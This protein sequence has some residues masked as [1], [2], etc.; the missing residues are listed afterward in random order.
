[1]TA[2]VSLIDKIEDKNRFEEAG[3]KE[4]LLSSGPQTIEIEEY[5][6]TFNALNPHL[7][8][9][10][11]S[12]TQLLP[13]KIQV[14]DS[15]FSLRVLRLFLSTIFENVTKFGMPEAGRIN[16]RVTSSLS[17]CVFEN[18]TND[19]TVEFDEKGLRGNLKL[20]QLL[21][22]N[23]NSGKLTIDPGDYKF[24]VTYEAR[25]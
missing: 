18:D 6:S 10:V 22:A 17:T 5:C 24:R 11:L 7:E 21:I 8:P 23:T 2:F 19:E 14:Y 4:G 25:K 3:L 20:F 13:L 15:F 9:I 1:M 12:I 16:L